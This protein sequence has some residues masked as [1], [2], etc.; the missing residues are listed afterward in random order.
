MRGGAPRPRPAG[1]LTPRRRILPVAGTQRRAG[2]GRAG[3]GGVQPALRRRQP[4]V[5]GAGAHGLSGRQRA[6]RRRLLHAAA[7]SL[8]ARGG[9]GH[10][11]P[12]RGPL[13]PPL[14]RDGRELD[15]RWAHPRLQLRRWVL[16]CRRKLPASCAL[17]QAPRPRRVLHPGPAAAWPDPQGRALCPSRPVPTSSLRETPPPCRRLPR[18]HGAH[19]GPAADP[20][21]QA[22]QAGPQGA[23]Q[24]R[25]PGGDGG[26]G[27]QAAAGCGCV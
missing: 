5:A 27:Q 14:G 26:L 9:G 25:G 6:R 3:G 20:Q 12:T 11:R 19:P 4:A 1:A 10:P 18:R 24:H 16:R 7:L 22:V 8:V 2:G 13:L 15:R 17:G 23:V 21:F